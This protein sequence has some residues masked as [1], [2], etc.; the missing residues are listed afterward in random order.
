M[1]NFLKRFLPVGVRRL[2]I[3]RFLPRILYAS[4]Y[5]NRRYW[6]ILKWG[7][8]SREDS[9]FTYDLTDLNIQ[10]LAWALS[11][12][13]RKT[14]SEI[15]GYLQEARNDFE[16]QRH[17]IEMARKPG[18]A[19]AAD[20]RCVF[21]RRLGWYAVVR[22]MKPRAVL[23]TGVDKG[24]GAVLLCSALLRNSE[25][26]YDGRYYGTDINGEAGYLLCRKYRKFG[27]ILYGDSIQSLK[28]FRGTID[29]FI[30]DS[31]HS[32]EYEY[33]EYQTIS[34]KL[35]RKAIILSDNS[36][37]TDRLAVFSLENGRR[38][39]FFPEVPKDHWYPGGG[40]G[41]SFCVDG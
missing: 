36:H 1:K 12:A 33:Q 20:P 8:R 41:I 26:G 14:Y 2:P 18:Q 27:E 37:V 23:E 13:T 34:G 9:N 7:F 11:V 40:I 22:A 4:S 31:D 35:G 29:L 32:A 21:G 38:F 28:R 16:L 30:H 3:V 17:V 25:E 15:H 5:Y 24:L 19:Y 10:Y 6:E 39:L